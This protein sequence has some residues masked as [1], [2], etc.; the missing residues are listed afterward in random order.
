MDL[1]VSVRLEVEYLGRSQT[2]K[3]TA[4]NLWFDYEDLRRFESELDGGGAARLH[5]MSAYPVLHFER[6]LSQEY[7]T[8]NPH[9]QRQSQDGDCM[10]VRLKVDSGTMHALYSALNQFGKWW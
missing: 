2:L 5:D 1:G 10:A 9:S 6:N 7:L 8:I 4:E 3:W